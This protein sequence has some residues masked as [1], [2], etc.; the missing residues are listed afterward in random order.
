MTRPDVRLIG[1]QRLEL[2]PGAA[3]RLTFR[4]HADLS[5]FTDR[6]GARVVEP[7]ALELR[8]GP[9]S[10][11]VRHRARLR[12]TGPTRVLGPG[13]RLRCEVLA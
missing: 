13:R 8:L 5:S 11:E 4:F 6:T 7:G 12:L 2:D 1:Y 9:S 3:R 10:A